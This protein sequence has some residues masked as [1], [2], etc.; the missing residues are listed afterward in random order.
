M[1]KAKASARKVAA[2]VSPRPSS[3][4]VTRTHLKPPDVT[5]LIS[6]ISSAPIDEL[7]PLL[8]SVLVWYYPRGDLQSWINVLDR[9]DIVLEGIITD[10]ALSLPQRNPFTPHTKNL[11]AEILRFL[12]LLFDNCTGRKAFN[13]YDV[14][15]LI[16]RPADISV[17]MT[18]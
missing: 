17:Y 10:Y 1:G 16:T 4:T 15:A 8:E 13:S 11:V 3:L 9:F 2:P 7:L 12:Q 6:L 14:S 18:S 5:E